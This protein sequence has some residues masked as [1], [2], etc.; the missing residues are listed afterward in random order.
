V[1]LVE[2]LVALA[3][4][5]ILASAISFAF[6]ASINIQRIQTRRQQSQVQTDGIER[7]M[8]EMIQGAWISNNTQ[9]QSSYFIGVQNNSTGELGCDQLVFTT[10]APTIPLVVQHNQDDFETQHRNFNTQGGVAE[11]SLSM[12]AVG[13]A[14][15]RVGVFE[16]IQRPPDTDPTQG[17]TESL[18]SGQIDQI[19]FQFWDGVQWQFEWDTINQTRRLPSAVKVSYHLQNAQAQD[20]RV[21]V[22]P[23]PNSDVDAQN[24][25]TNSQDNTGTNTT[26]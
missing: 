7:R 24:P 14:G 10:T 16:R 9:D 20:I 5:V 15:N 26:Q 2:L 8:T 3:L 21:L 4:M 1:T 19:G 13:N 18:L 22:I 11:V 17:G 25:V 23:I 6:T 12:T